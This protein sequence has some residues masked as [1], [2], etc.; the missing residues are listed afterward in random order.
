MI[1]LKFNKDVL[2]DVLQVDQANKNLRS[3]AMP[4]TMHFLKRHSWHTLRVTLSM[5]HL[6][7]NLQ[8]Y[9]G[10]RF[11]WMVRRKNPC[12]GSHGCTEAI[13]DHSPA[14]RLGAQDT[15]HRGTPSAW[16]GACYLAALTGDA[17]VV[18]AGGFVPAHDAQ[19]VFV[20]VTRDVPWGHKEEQASTT[21]VNEIISIETG[22]TQTHV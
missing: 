4:T 18:V 14:V 11:F 1:N 21:S 12:K 16:K 17:A 8:A 2:Q 19:L 7:S 5:T 10:L 15:K 22:K 13:K 6:A 9:E 3:V 20:E